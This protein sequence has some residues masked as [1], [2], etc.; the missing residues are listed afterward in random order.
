[1]GNL[2][3]DYEDAVFSGNRKYNIINNADGT[4]SLLDA[5]EYQ[6]QDKDK[7]YFGAKDINDVNKEI[8]NKLGKTETAERAIA[9]KNGIDITAGY[10][11]NYKINTKFSAPGWY[12]IVGIQTADQNIINGSAGQSFIV[13]INRG[14]STIAPEQYSILCRNVYNTAD[15][16][17]YSKKIGNVQTI[18]KARCIKETNGFYID[19]YY[20]QDV[21]W[22]DLS[23]SVHQNDGAWNTYVN[24][25]S[26]VI[27]TSSV[28][29]PIAELDLVNTKD[30]YSSINSLE[31][32][33]NTVSTS[34]GNF[35]ADM[36]SLN[37][38]LNNLAELVDIRTKFLSSPVCVGTINSIPLY[39]IYKRYS[40]SD[41][42]EGLSSGSGIFSFSLD[43]IGIS[44]KAGVSSVDNFSIYN[45]KCIGR[46]PRTSNIGTFA[47]TD[48]TSGLYITS[49]HEDADKYFILVEL[50][51]QA[52]N[53]DEITL[54][55]EYSLDKILIAEG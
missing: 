18:T 12:R 21:L 46:K 36:G 15:L 42:P 39:K 7:V 48:I 52:G 27:I 31:A 25:I 23:I 11:K 37:N 14:F 30:I 17:L 4:V 13:N 28:A 26:P 34:I 33:F 53:W 54:F 43:E 5:T 51:L 2:R 50:D 41:L 32:N 20:S 1:M 19:I 49:M 10:L 16:K 29:T 38:R 3:T 22:N 44:T 45:I 55:I 8:N 9:D 35:G 47:Y 24:V 40:S 6:N